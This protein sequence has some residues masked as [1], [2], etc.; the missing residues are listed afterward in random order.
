MSDIISVSIPPGNYNALTFATVLSRAMTTASLH[1]W[2]YQISFPNGYV[3]ANTGKFTITVTGNGNLPPGNANQPSLIFDTNSVYEQMGFTQGTFAFTSN[4][5]ES[6]NVICMVPE[7]N[8]L[9]HS[10]ICDN[11]SDDVLETVYYNN[12]QPLSNA[13][14]QCNDVLNWSKKLRTNQSNTYTFSITDEHNFELNLNGRNV[15]FSIILFRG[16]Y[17]P[18]M[19]PQN[20]H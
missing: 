12:N 13:T 20:S 6:P 1:S 4:S 18:P 10:D 9:I 2:V 5:L 17:L 7:T 11:G 8:I 14:F 19:T 3:Q 15:L 16:A